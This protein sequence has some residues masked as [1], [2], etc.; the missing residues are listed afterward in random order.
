MEAHSHDF[1]SKQEE[2]SPRHSCPYDEKLSESTRGVPLGCP[3]G[4]WD[5]LWWEGGP[6]HGH[7]WYSDAT[8]LGQCVVLGSLPLPAAAGGGSVGLRP[9]TAA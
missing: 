5:A 1:A 6:A 4:W 7:K 8:L 9:M 2:R 3:L